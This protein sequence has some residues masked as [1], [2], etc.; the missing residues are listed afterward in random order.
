MPWL[1]SA[2]LDASLLS[3]MP[4]G[5][6]ADSMVVLEADSPSKGQERSSNQVGGHVLKLWSS[7]LSLVPGQRQR[8]P[9]RIDLHPSVDSI[10]A[11]SRC[12]HFEQGD[13]RPDASGDLVPQRG[14]FKRFDVH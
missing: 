5:H 2:T 1:L 8:A 13:C 3:S 10:P 9:K 4:K 7:F 6:T 11:Q 12:A 14:E